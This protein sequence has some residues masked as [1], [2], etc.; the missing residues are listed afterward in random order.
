MSIRKAAIAIFFFLAIGFVGAQIASAVAVSCSS[1]INVVPGDTINL[2]AP[3]AP[4]GVIYYYLWTITSGTST[5]KTDANQQSSFTVPSAGSA[6]S[7]YTAT[8]LVGSGTTTS[9]AGLSGCVLSSCLS[10]NVQL[11]NTCQI[12]GA[13]SVCQTDNAE[14]YTYTGTADIAGTI[15]GTQ[16][17]YLTWFVDGSQI[18]NNDHSGKY[19]VDWTKYW[20]GSTNAEAHKVSV[21]VHSTKSGKVLSNCTLNVNV[22]PSPVATITP[23]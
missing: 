18:A 7:S 10:I 20:K 22:L 21:D 1:A 16:T 6:A 13:Q 9:G 15:S 8:L 23:T 11:S 14:T 19:T 12:A 2:S 17:A 3:S 4:S 5:V